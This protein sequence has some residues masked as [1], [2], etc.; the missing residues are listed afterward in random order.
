MICSFTFIFLII[1]AVASSIAKWSKGS[2]NIDLF[3]KM[4]LFL[5]LFGIVDII[6]SYPLLVSDFSSAQPF[7][8]QI[9]TNLVSALLFSL[10]F[11]FM[12]S[13]VFSSMSTNRPKT[14]HRFTYFEIV[15]ISLIVIGFTSRAFNISSMTPTWIPGMDV[16]NSYVPFLKNLK[17][18]IF[19]YFNQVIIML[20]MVN[21]MDKTKYFTKKKRGLIVILSSTVFAFLFLGTHL[22][23]DTAINSVGVWIFGSFWILM[24][25]A[26]LYLNQF[27]YNMAMIPLVISIV[28]G[29]NLLAA[30]NSNAYPGILIGNVICSLVII[31][32]GYYMYLSLLNLNEEGNV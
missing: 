15:A 29:F 3:K 17:D 4:F 14:I 10:I 1:Y 9:A 31:V 8:N 2:F 7:I 26:S 24:I 28:T 5:A 22:G 32:I 11:S 21:L 16:V 6:N 13:V 23:G 30:A 19:S 12:L 25:F 18:T 20:F 27:I